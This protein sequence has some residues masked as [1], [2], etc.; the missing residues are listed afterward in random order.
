MP[1][2]R[3]EIKLAGDETSGFYSEVLHAPGL[4]RTDHAALA[5]SDKEI[6]AWRQAMAQG[7]FSA[8][9]TLRLGRHLFEALFSGHILRLWESSLGA[10]GFDGGLRVRLDIRSSALSAIPWELMHDGYTYLAQTVATPVVRCLSNHRRPRHSDGNSTPAVLVV[11]ATP[12]NAPRLPNVDAEV[13]AILNNLCSMKVACELLPHAT[14]NSLQAKLREANYD[15]IHY[16]GHGVFDGHQGHL[17]LEDQAGRSD[18]FDSASLGRF[19][20]DT[21]VGLLF[22]NCCETAVPSPAETSQGAAEASLV[23][24]IPTVVAMSAAVRDDVAT[25]FAK[26]F[27]EVLL[28]QHSVEYC[29]AEARKAIA[30]YHAPYW[31]IP[32]LFTNTS[33]EAPRKSH[34]AI[35]QI[36]IE[37]HGKTNIVGNN[38][39]YRG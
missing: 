28:E 38:V 22:L 3:F 33:D 25:E 31:A 10:I 32:V 30:H 18:R 39:N 9:A 13:N 4:R 23:V 17:V 1:Y 12:S 2:E 16:I 11:T 35:P 29:M 21:N 24:G 20:A 37:Q 27:Y 14:R 6:R 8:E 26:Q 36:T 19:L 7:S 34:K 5:L 15:I